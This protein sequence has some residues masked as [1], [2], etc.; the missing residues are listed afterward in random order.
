[1]SGYNGPAVIITEDDTEVLV[2]ANLR[3]Y[4]AGLRTDWSG[5]LA[6]SA[7]ALRQ[8][9]NLTKGRLRLPDGNEADFLRPDTSHW[10]TS[11]RLAIIGQDEAPF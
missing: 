7:D 8:L 6:P 10:V 11:K 3:R 9:A 2:T 1:M 4:R 5:T